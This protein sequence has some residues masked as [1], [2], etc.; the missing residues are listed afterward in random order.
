MGLFRRP[1]DR[2]TLGFSFDEEAVDARAG[3]T[4]ATALIDAGVLM[5][6]RSAKYRRPR[7]PYCLTGDCGTCMV[8]VDGRPNVKACCTAAKPGM[9]VRAQNTYRPKGLDPTQLVDKIFTSGFDHHHFMVKPRIANVVMQTVARELTGFGDLPDAAWDGEAAHRHHEPTVLV[10]GLGPA[11]N[12][13]AHALR[14]AGI[15]VVCIDRRPASAL[16]QGLEPVPDA[17]LETG[18]FAAYAGETLWAATGPVRD[19]TVLHTV[20]A[21]HVVIATG[22]RDPML[23]FPNNDV[24]GVVSARGLLRVLESTGSSLDVPVVVIGRGA[25][26]DQ[27]AKQLDAERIDPEEVETIEGSTRVEGVKVRGKKTLD[28]QL[29]AIAGQPAP[30]S[31]LARQAGA[32]VRWDGGGFAI[33]RDKSGRC[34]RFGDAQLYAT[35]DVTGWIGPEASAADGERVGN[36]VA[37]IVEKLSDNPGG[38]SGQA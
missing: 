24:P 10:L 29:V 23:P 28:C 5:T 12:A 1:E 6:S 9:V 20:R 27:C 32:S 35:G 38:D 34:G 25:L 33:E 11:G 16:P 8:R 13:A 15:D 4:I 37:K 14:A 19:K 31:E 21:K 3:D 26:A 30:C 2:E 18:M 22:A 17:L 36:S 7:G